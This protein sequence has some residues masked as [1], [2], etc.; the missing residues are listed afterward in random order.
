MLKI[1]DK[2][3]ESKEGEEEKIVPLNIVYLI[4]DCFIYSSRNRGGWCLCFYFYMQMQKKKLT[5]TMLGS[6]LR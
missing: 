3:N 6:N 2:T 1:D 4:S 5:Y